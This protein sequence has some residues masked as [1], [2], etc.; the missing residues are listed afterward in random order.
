VG[1]ASLLL[2]DFL[3]P[4]GP[5]DEARRL[6]EVVDHIAELAV[7]H[8]PH[9]SDKLVGSPSRLA[10]LALAL[11]VDLRLVEIGDELV[12]PLPAAARFLAVDPPATADGDVQ[13]PLW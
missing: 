5:A 11:L 1:H 4:C 13:R 9:W 8:A 6:S 7:R 2:L 12:R 10:K 3:R